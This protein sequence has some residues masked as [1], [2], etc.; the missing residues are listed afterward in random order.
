MAGTLLRDLYTRPHLIDAHRPKTI[1]LAVISLALESL[2]LEVADADW[3][4]AI[5][6][7]QNLTRLHRLKSKIVYALY[8]E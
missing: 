6:G 7:K 4:P 2:E 8:S 5:Q 3:V 1:A